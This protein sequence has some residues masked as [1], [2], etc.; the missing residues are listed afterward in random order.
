MTRDEIIGMARQAGLGMMLED[1]T[2]SGPLWEP[3][4]E[5]FAELVARHEREACAA[6]CDKVKVITPEY[7]LDQHYNQASAHCA[8]AI[9]GRK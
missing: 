4:L 7:Q 1:E 6:L 9:R 3:E 8:R 5:R 2:T